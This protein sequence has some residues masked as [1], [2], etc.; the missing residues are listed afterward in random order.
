MSGEPGVARRARQLATPN[1]SGRRRELP[2]AQMLTMGEAARLL[3]VHTNT[4]R[5]WANEGRL[6]A[7]RI[8]TSGDRRFQREEVEL[9][10]EEPAGAPSRE[11]TDSTTDRAAAG[12]L[13]RD[14]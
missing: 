6:R 10:L 9:L 13:R 4:V 11:S 7:Y 3:G 1:A 2:S 12:P 14:A 8:G 5:K